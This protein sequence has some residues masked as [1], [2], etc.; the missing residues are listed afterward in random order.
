MRHR[1]CSR[2]TTRRRTSITFPFATAEGIRYDAGDCRSGRDSPLASSQTR[3]AVHVGSDARRPRL[4]AVQVGGSDTE[5]FL[6]VPIMSG[7]RVIGVIALE[8]A[9]HARLQRSDERLPARRSPSSM[10]VALENARLFDETKRLLTDSN[11]RAAELA[12]INEIGGG[13]RRAARLPG[14]H[15]P[16][17]RTRSGRSSSHC[18]CSSRFY[19][20]ATDIAHVPVRPGRRGVASQRRV[21]PGRAR[22]HLDRPRSGRPLRIGTARGAGELRRAPG[23][24]LGHRVVAGRPDPGGDRVIGVIGL[25]SLEANAFSEG[26]DRLLTRF[27]RASASPSRT[28]GCSTRRSAS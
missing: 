28:P 11:E 26:D 14:D 1:R 24:R 25:E 2:S 18:P 10:G 4:G 12:V 7:D 15:R 6:G 3:A 20:P 19:D 13:A 5:S 23:R 16:R 8:Q 17:R 22:H 21:D 27:R 9:E